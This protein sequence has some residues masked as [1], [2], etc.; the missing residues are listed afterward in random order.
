M[1]NPP[2]GVGSGVEGR[3][4]GLAQE[5]AVRQLYMARL[6]LCEVLS[7]T[8]LCTSSRNSE[9]YLNIKL[10]PVIS[11]ISGDCQ[12]LAKFLSGI[13]LRWGDMRLSGCRWSEVP[14]PLP[15]PN[16]SLPRVE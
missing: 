16:F 12:P 3:P 9:C 7:W 4:A 8:T 10:V 6:R 14:R 15:L 11:F 5:R 2:L 1:P 13:A